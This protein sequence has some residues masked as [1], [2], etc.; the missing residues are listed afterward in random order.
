V[1]GI[2]SANLKILLTITKKT[3]FFVIL[4]FVWV[5][6]NVTTRNHKLQPVPMSIRL[7]R[8]LKLS[9]KAQK[10]FSKTVNKT[11]KRIEKCGEN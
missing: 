11:E 6:V 2:D 7:F 3:F 4:S 5:P 8:V 10:N 1:W 9:P